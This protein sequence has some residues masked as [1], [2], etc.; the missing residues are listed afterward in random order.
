M[1]RSQPVSQARELRKKETGSEQILWSWLRNNQLNGAKFRR[2]QPI[3]IYVV[4]FVCFDKRLI[5]EI[6]GGQHNEDQIIARDELRT[7]WL[8][9]QGFR[10][11]RFW[12]ND[13]TGNLEGVMLKI[14]EVLD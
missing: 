4:D 10:V 13:V 6:D 12:N 5:I 8:E 3:G 14:K 11:I 2:Q 1:K 7:V 9:D